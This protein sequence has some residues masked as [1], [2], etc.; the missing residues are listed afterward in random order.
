MLTS[1]SIDVDW[2]IWKDLF[3]G[4]VDFR[5][6]K[7]KIRDINSQPWIDE[8]VVNLQHRKDSTSGIAKK[9]GSSVIWETFR[10]LRSE[11]Q[12]RNGL[13]SGLEQVLRAP[14]L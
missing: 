8:K 7:S 4:A 9:T 5:V 1:D 14:D 10:K 2:K 13:W 6:P 3:S 12:W 11:A